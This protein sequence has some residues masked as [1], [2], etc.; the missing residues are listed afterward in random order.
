MIPALFVVFA[1]L[2]VGCSLM[3]VLHRNPVVSALFLVLAFCALAALFLLLEAQFLAM[4]QVLVY[5]GAIMVLFLFVLMYLNLRRDLEDGFR[6]TVRRALG[7]FVG[8][9][10]FLE[11]FLLFRGSWAL[12]PADAPLPARFDPGNT[13]AVG[14]LLFSRYLL[15]FELTSLVLLVAIVGAVVIGKGRGGA[16]KGEGR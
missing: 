10:L 2:L 3:V 16:G 8:A 12:G 7:W 11:G 14:R 1:A 6:F 13:Q 5:A 9:L 15:P 4:V